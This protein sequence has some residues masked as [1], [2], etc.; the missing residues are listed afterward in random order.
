MFLMCC[1]GEGLDGWTDG[2]IQQV[3]LVDFTTSTPRVI[4]MHMT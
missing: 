3:V 2:R 1:D 4:R